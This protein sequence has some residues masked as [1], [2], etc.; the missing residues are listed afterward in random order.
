MTVAFSKR[1]CLLGLTALA[2]FAANAAV[3]G[4]AEVE[5]LLR[6]TPDGSTVT[7]PDG[8]VR[9]ERALEVF[10][11][12]NLVIRGG[13]GTRLLAHVSP[14]GPT[15]ETHGVFKVRSCQSV[16]FED[17]TLS[18]DVPPNCAG[19]IVSLDP[20]NGLYDVSVDDE[21]PI[22]GN[23]HLCA[24]NTCDDEGMPDWAIEEYNTLHEAKGTNGV[25][26]YVG[27]NYRV[28]GPQRIRLAPPWG[29]DFDFSKLH[30]GH[31]IVYRYL[32]YGASAFEFENCRDI[33]VRKVEVERCPCFAVRISP[34]SADFTFDGM[35]VRPPAGSK[36]IYSANA[37]GIHILGLSGHLRLHDCHFDGLG[38]D[39]LNL[40]AKAGEV[41]D[42]DAATGRLKLICRHVDRRE[43]PLPIGWAENGSR[44]VVYDGKT[45]VEKG[46]VLLAEYS[47]DAGC[48]RIEAGNV[49]VA[50]GDILANERDFA[51]VQI[52][53][54]SFRNGRARGVLLQSRN[55]RV[56][57]SLFEGFALPG[58]LFALD[59]DIWYEVGA[60]SNVE[61][62]NCRFRK[63]GLAL[64][65]MNLGALAVKTGHEV[66]EEDMRPA[67]VHRDFRLLGNRFENCGNSGVYLSSTD[68]VV[69]RGNEFKNCS[70]RRYDKSNPETMC[71]IRLH[72]CANV[73]IENNRTDKPTELLVGWK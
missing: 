33:T 73:R 67:G 49:T 51:S 34:Q 15:D 68:G 63:C 55:I 36:A 9:L 22:T 12:T 2:A 60:A 37:D 27:A 72:N 53:D 54:C 3:S 20:V 62:R 50:N 17:L 38:D 11:R 29:K 39:C 14:S 70:A 59:A 65:R 6:A 31:R 7:L 26:R 25:V 8:E 35:N 71:D 5:A 16:R 1:T 58:L 18:T 45:L 40:H 13:K 57:N 69:I 21:F 42:F 23:E 19:R 43:V 46:T 52:T 48:G 61:V 10:C 44:I 32:T 30:V 24:A 56:E 4:V 66:G 47:R 28:V 41:K 64:N